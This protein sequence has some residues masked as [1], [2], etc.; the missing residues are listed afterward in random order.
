MLIIIQ[1]YAK[2][3]TFPSVELHCDTSNVDVIFVTTLAGRFRTKKAVVPS[4]NTSSG[5]VEFQ[6]FGGCA[7]NVV[8]YT[9]PNQ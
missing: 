9:E 6:H 5:G 8:Y 4:S 2:S 7:E 1:V 3:L